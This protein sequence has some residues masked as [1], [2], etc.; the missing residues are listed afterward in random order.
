MRADDGLKVSHNGVDYSF[1]PDTVIAALAVPSAN[2]WDATYST[3][4][5]SPTVY[6]TALATDGTVI[7]SRRTSG[8]IRNGAGLYV[9]SQPL[10]GRT[11]F[12]A[13]WDE[14]DANDFVSEM[15]V[16]V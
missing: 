7:T 12:V 13:V 1:S 4:S 2:T 6:Y 15:I 8:V 9:Y 5:A 16:L 3:I 14:G 10:G 11:E